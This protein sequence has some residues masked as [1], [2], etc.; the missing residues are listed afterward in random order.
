MHEG[1]KLKR[2]VDFTVFEVQAVAVFWVGLVQLS[3][4]VQVQTLSPPLV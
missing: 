4:D 1:L 2:G 3:A